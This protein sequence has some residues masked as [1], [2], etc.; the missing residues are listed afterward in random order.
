MKIADLPY[1]VKFVFLCGGTGRTTSDI[2]L[3]SRI[4]R[5]SLHERAFS[6]D[7]GD[8]I[9]FE[10]ENDNIYR[11]SSI[12]I[13]QLLDDTKDMLIGVDLED[14]DLQG[15]PKEWLMKILVTMELE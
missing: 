11:I 9:Y 4:K 2:N 6:L 15:E 5:A 1:Y 12:S 13:K 8:R 10:P 7:V 14:S 3:I